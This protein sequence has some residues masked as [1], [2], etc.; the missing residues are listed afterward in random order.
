MRDCPAPDQLI[1]ALQLQVGVVIC[2]LCRSDLRLLLV[3]GGFERIL[4]DRKDH[5]VLLD[6]VAILEQARTEKPAHASANI[7]FFQGVGAAD[8]LR[9]LSNRS[10]L[11]GLDQNR[12]RRGLLRICR[13]AGD[14][15]RER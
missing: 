8:V 13:K 6:R 9:L 15:R 10:K 5:L 3:D 12:G 4:V 1:A 14:S 7:H 11:G 2:R